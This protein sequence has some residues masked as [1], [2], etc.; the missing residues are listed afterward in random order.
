MIYPTDCQGSGCGGK[1]EWEKTCVPPEFQGSWW[2]D[3]RTAT[4]FPRSP[5]W[6]SGYV[7]PLNL[8]LAGGGQGAV[9]STRFS[10]LGIYAENRGRTENRMGAPGQL[11]QS[12]GG[13][14]ERAGEEGRWV[15]STRT[16]V[17]GPGVA[18]VQEGL[19]VGD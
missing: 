10:V 11:G 15:V 1:R 17:F 3:A 2:V 14:E 9:L 18:G 12:R 16:R 8:S 4:G 13:R 19:P 6:V 7:K 5:R